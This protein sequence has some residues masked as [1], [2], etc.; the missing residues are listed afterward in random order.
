LRS[1]AQPPS[2]EPLESQFHALPVV[3]GWSYVKVERGSAVRTET[4]SD[5]VINDVANAVAA[6]VDYPVVSVKWGCISVNLRKVL[7]KATRTRG[8][9]LTLTAI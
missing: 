9:R 2:A 6:P 3:E 5:I 1:D 8:R 7:R 4:S